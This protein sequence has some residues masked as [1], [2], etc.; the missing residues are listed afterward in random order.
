[1]RSRT[2][3]AKKKLQAKHRRLKVESMEM[4]TQHKTKGTKSNGLYQ[5][6]DLDP[7]ITPLTLVIAI[8]CFI[9]LE[10]G[11]QNVNFVVPYGIQ[12]NEQ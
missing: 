7:A 5:V 9:L 12:C 1:V 10:D 4:T 8:S 2:R 11:A 3:L 6:H